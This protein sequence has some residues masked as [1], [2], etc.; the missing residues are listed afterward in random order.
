MTD[1]LNPQISEPTPLNATGP[2]NTQTPPPAA[3]NAAA[4]N[5]DPSQAG[6]PVDQQVVQSPNPQ[7]P[8]P[9]A[10]HASWINDTLTTL[11]GGPRF[12]TSYNPDTNAVTR[13]KVPFSGREVGMAI[14]LHALS[15]ALAGA[16][17]KGTN[18]VGKAG[19]AGLQQGQQIAA[20]QRQKDQDE[21]KAADEQYRQHA[22][23]IETNMKMAQNAATLGSMDY[24]MH[25]KYI[26]N[27]KPLYDTMS[28]IPGAIIAEGVTEGDLANKY[29]IAKDAAIPTGIVERLDANGQPVLGRNGQQQY[30]NTYAVI[31]PTAK[32]ELPDETLKFLQDHNVPG[33]PKDLKLPEGM[34]QKAQL[35]LNG[36]AKA[37]AIQTAEQVLNTHQ[38]AA[39]TPP[40]KDGSTSLW[41]M[42]PSNEELATAIAQHEGSKPTDRNVRNNN[43]GNLKTTGT[44]G[45][46]K[47]GF[48]KYNT[49]EEGFN[50]LL[51]DISAKQKRMPDATPEQWA[52]IYSP[53]ADPGNGPGT[54][55]AYADAL[56]KAAGIKPPTAE[57][58]AAQKP[59]ID[60]K[61]EI[62]Q[63]PSLVHSLE[64]YAKYAGMPPD[65]AIEAMS[66]D[67]EASPTD[68]GNMTRLLGGPDAI[69]QI[70]IARAANDK[71]V[72]ERADP[73]K[74]AQIEHT[75]LE[76]QKLESDAAAQKRQEAMMVE[77]ANFKIPDGGFK[78]DATD[79]KGNLKGQSV[80][81]PD[82][83]DALYAIA[84][85]KADLKTLP[86]KSYRGTNTMDA[87]HGLDYIHKYINPDYIE[88]DYPAAA[89]LNQEMASTRPGTAGGSLLFAGTASN[90]LG[91]LEQAGE[92]LNNGNVQALNALANAFH[93]QIGDSPAVTFKA[94][95]DNVN[96][97]VGKV[98]AGGSPHQTELD[99]LRQ[100][101][102]RKQS[103]EQI[104]S[105]IDSYIGLMDGRIGEISD[106]SKQ[107]FGR[108]IHVSPE[109]SAL[110]TKYGYGADYIDKNAQPTSR[111]TTAAQTNPD[112]IPTVQNTAKTGMLNNK[113]VYQ[114]KNGAHVFAD[115][116]TAQ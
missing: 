65:K 44:A 116:S 98:L 95:A 91:M 75:N 35:Y 23:T 39:Q 115:G 104:H 13:E 61:K 85:N 36:M 9:V 92:A 5:T 55:Q 25:G 78:M 29:H 3:P 46:D 109:T 4:P 58:I 106:R 86:Q 26:D 84:H 64:Q 11:S 8:N 107:Y 50:A 28:Q 54:E 112:N 73:A 31:D 100:N 69:H 94:I 82:N 1:E 97:E 68:V 79:L 53:D 102:N 30:D 83:F 81:I 103:P 34:K 12:K 71:L 90:H 42:F 105:V 60:L 59:P 32:I 76:N 48:A 113:K 15:G 99:E 70:A 2:V 96:A 89:K 66:K 47:D 49:T 87:Q 108:D 24:T 56:R 52:H 10:K 19:A 45:V 77:P 17:E 114:L 18:A 80:P 37:Q 6:K 43:P 62:A 93:V 67:K 88:S 101:L 22:A 57:A 111:K 72:A 51:S 14:A 63:N 41:G 38:E 7:P 33:Y 40:A 20:Q 27:Y 16:G 110:F 74:Q 21:Q